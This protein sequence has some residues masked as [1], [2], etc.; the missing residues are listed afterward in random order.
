VKARE[1]LEGRAVSLAE[2]LDWAKVH[3]LVA[4]IEEREGLEPRSLKEAMR[5]AGWEL[6][7]WAMEEELAMLGDA[8]MW[9]LVDAPFGANIVG[10]KWVFKAKKDAARNVI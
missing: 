2:E 10:S 3:V 1:I 4:E 8:G 9:E 6:W 7:K 5:R